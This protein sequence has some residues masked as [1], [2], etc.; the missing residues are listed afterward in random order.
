MNVQGVCHFSKASGNSNDNN[1]FQIIYT[2]VEGKLSETFLRDIAENIGIDWKR[3]A[4]N[5]GFKT[6]QIT[7][8]EQDNRD[9]LKEQAF[10]MFVAWQN[11][12]TDI[13]DT[14]RSL[15]E[16]LDTIERTDLASR[17]PGIS[18]DYYYLR[19]LMY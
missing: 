13:E 3:L 9:N 1:K 17:I 4:T 11:K 15:I 7:A 12:Q 6:A 10:K 5:L 8:F 2:A 14:R 16:A 19:R 18:Y